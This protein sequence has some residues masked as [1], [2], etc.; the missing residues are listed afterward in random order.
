MKSNEEIDIEK[1]WV[2]SRDMGNG[3][4]F[5]PGFGAHRYGAITP[6]FIAEN[7]AIALGQ[8]LVDQGICTGYLARQI[9]PPWRFM[10]QA[11]AQ[12]LCA[13]QLQGSSTSELQGYIFANR[14]EE[15]GHHLPT[16]LIDPRNL[17]EICAITPLG[18]KMVRYGD[19]VPWASYD[20]I[21]QRLGSLLAESPF[22]GFS[23]GQ[24][25]FEIRSESSIVTFA[26]VNILG[27]YINTEGAIAFFSSRELAEQTLARLPSLRHG[28]FTGIDTV[29]E[30]TLKV[31][32]IS[33]LAVRLN[34]LQHEYWA[35]KY[36]INPHEHRSASA[37]GMFVK[38]QPK[39]CAQDAVFDDI[40]E[41][42][43]HWFRSV[44]GVWELASQNQLLRL[45]SAPNWLGC[46]TLYKKSGQEI[47]LL[48]L[49]RTTQ[50]GITLPFDFTPDDVS[51][52]E[53]EEAIEGF[54]GQAAE[55]GPR[56]L[57]EFAVPEL[58]SK[59]AVKVW[60]TVDGEVPPPWIFESPLHAIQYLC[61]FERSWDRKF[62]ETGA[63]GCIALGFSGTGDEASEAQKSERYAK[64]ML[65]IANKIACQGYIPA[66]AE[67]LIGIC[68]QVLRTIQ[69]TY[70]GYVGDLWFASDGDVKAQLIEEFDLDE[71]TEAELESHLAGPDIDPQS[72]A[73]LLARIGDDG[74]S[75]LSDKSRLFL[76]TA[77]TQIA[78]YGYAPGFDYA[79][80]S[81]E[82]VKALEVELQEIFQS[83]GSSLSGVQ[84]KCDDQNYEE[85]ALIKS[86]EGKAKPPS[87]GAMGS[88]LKRAR[89][90][91]GSDL[92]KALRAFLQSQSNEDYIL[93]SK[94]TRLLNGKV[95]HK[96]R[97]AGAHDSA[98]SYETCSECLE[99][100]VG[101]AGKPGVIARI[102]S[103]K[104][105]QKVPGQ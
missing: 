74:F 72:A 104:P 62:R 12:G 99:V 38:P 52:V 29:P 5:L 14:V 86:L 68:N 103:W 13:I 70:A 17:D 65:R 31:Y 98:I 25:F 81:I 93:S 33:D 61:S 32:Q 96:Y 55:D 15:A 45:D 10:Q 60:D 50:E 6:A 85:N 76:A 2:L 83:F 36:C 71:D 91:G 49:S 97:N 28:R 58:K 19:V 79:P 20:L 94:F 30:E 23:A 95:L 26:D 39:N 35:I 48:P 77:I 63:R 1:W 87:L 43:V 27:D 69:L 11:A 16:L 8:T 102:A 84:L 44:S 47:Q 57:T 24:P 51:T 3:E 4:E 105:K 64:G 7:E 40:F 67:D 90:D 53:L 100:L 59:F 42:D 88:L 66:D 89:Q 41:R 82:I 22:S 37:W 101:S 75:V 46:D 80:M 21:D 78:D 34:E 9:G 18:K 92:V 56:E 73:A 54:I